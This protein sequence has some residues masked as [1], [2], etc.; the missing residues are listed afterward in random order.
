MTGLQ[1]NLF[2]F[3]STPLNLPSEN[4]NKK[5]PQGV[6]VAV[7]VRVRWG[8][9]GKG[10]LPC[11]QEF[12]FFRPYSRCGSFTDMNKLVET[13]CHPFNFGNNIMLCHPLNSTFPLPC[14]QVKKWRNKKRNRKVNT[15][16]LCHII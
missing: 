12:R 1:I 8:G 9:V 4:N 3:A 5:V 2:D 15:T 6:L 11:F 7:R 16:G 14:E 10:G 13:K